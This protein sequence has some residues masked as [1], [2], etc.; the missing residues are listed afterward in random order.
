M[1][2]WRS[3]PRGWTTTRHWAQQLSGGEQQR[4]ALARALLAKPDW[5][6]LD[7]ATASLDPEAEADLYRTL[8]ARLPNTTLVSIA[9]RPSVAAFH[10]R[11]LVLRR[12]EGRPGELVQTELAAAAGGGG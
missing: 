5:L 3:S 8:K 6:F 7:E 1:R 10:D 12:E 2:A 4:V 11:R 9:H